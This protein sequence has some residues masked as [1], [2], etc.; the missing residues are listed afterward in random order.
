MSMGLTLVVA[1]VVSLVVLLSYGNRL[2]EWMGLE[3]QER[4]RRR[5]VQE[6]LRQYM[7]RHPVERGEYAPYRRN[8]HK[9]TLHSAYWRRQIGG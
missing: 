7:D 8:G 6:E 1:V 9:P 3:D 4:I 2:S 5:V